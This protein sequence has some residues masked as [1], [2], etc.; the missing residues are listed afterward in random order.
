MIDDATNMPFSFFLFHKGMLE[1]RLVL[2]IKKLKTQHDIEEKIIRY[3]NPG[4]TGHL[5]KPMGRKFLA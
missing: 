1:I 2:F 3:D 4:E 5:K